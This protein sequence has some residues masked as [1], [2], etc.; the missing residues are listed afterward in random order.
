MNPLSCYGEVDPIE[1][2]GI[3]NIGEKDCVLEPTCALAQE[4]R[5]KPA[6]VAALQA[7]VK[8]QGD[9]REY[10]R[11]YQALRELARTKRPFSMDKC[12]SLGDAV[13]AFLAPEDSTILTTNL[14]DHQPLAAA[15]GKT[16]T[17]RL[18][19]DR[20]VKER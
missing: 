8:M 16:A 11:R 1:N 17:A 14:R 3:I 7:V 20:E 19:N 2:R 9:S 12:R 18:P 13:F 10:Q 4:F 15:L 5:K 6:D